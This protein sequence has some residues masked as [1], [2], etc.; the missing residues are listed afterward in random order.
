MNTIDEIRN[1]VKSKIFPSGIDGTIDMDRDTFFRFLYYR[2]KF[3]LKTVSMEEVIYDIYTSSRE[4]FSID[5]RIQKISE[6]D[7]FIIKVINKTEISSFFVDKYGN[8]FGV[9]PF[10][11]HKNNSIKRDPNIKSFIETY[12]KDG[13]IFT[14]TP[15]EIEKVNEIFSSHEFFS[16]C[17][18]DF[19][20]RIHEIEIFFNLISPIIIDTFIKNDTR[21][22]D[23]MK[24]MMS[25][26][27]NL[28]RAGIRVDKEFILKLINMDSNSI[29]MVYNFIINDSS[30][31]EIKGSIN[32][33]FVEKAINLSTAVEVVDK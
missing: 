5:F 19:S 25:L 4:D 10:F 9:F 15:D 3:V 27:S 14:L 33:E 1:V 21:E 29:T 32:D 2:Y 31:E 18:K 30:F 8:T 20:K 22:I 17:Y 12:Q 24:S 13:I 11:Q 26:I 6:K 28:E 16:R 23:V 7:N